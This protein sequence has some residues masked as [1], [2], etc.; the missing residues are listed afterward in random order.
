MKTI[1][2]IGIPGAGKTHYASTHY[3]LADQVSADHY[4]MERGRYVFDH[5]R[6]ETAHNKCLQKFTEMVVVKHEGPIVV[7]NTNLK[8]RDIAPY[9][10]LSLAYGRKVE[11]VWFHVRPEV[12]AQRNLHGVGEEF[13]MRA[14]L[15]FQSLR[16][17]F[18]KEWNVTHTHI[19]DTDPLGRDDKSKRDRVPHKE[20]V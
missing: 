5:K 4:L 8:Q 12:A 10:M 11:V 9:V 20:R 17:N 15:R 2:F 6:L 14:E 1:I 7:D 13:C 16:R 18:P 19:R 3:P